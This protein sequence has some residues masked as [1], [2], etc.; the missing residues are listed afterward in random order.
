MN[1]IQRTAI[2]FLIITQVVAFREVAT[3]DATLSVKLLTGV[4][5]GF[6]LYS[7]LM[8]HVLFFAWMVVGFDEVKGFLWSVVDNE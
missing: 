8:A 6:V 2:G 1:S 3:I 5:T 4:L 7:I